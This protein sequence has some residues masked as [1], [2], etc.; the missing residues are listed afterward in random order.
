MCKKVFR[1]KSPYRE[2]F[3]KIYEKNLHVLYANC[4]NRCFKELSAQKHINIPAAIQSALKSK[5]NLIGNENKKQFQKKS[6]KYI[7]KTRKRWFER[8]HIK[9][10]DEK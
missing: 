1:E 5:K 2:G 9:R 4:Q 3:P 6:K 10:V 8:N 7:P